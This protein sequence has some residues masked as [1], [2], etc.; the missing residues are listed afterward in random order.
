MDPSLLDPAQALALCCCGGGP[1]A[2]L[3]L[4]VLSKA[5]AGLSDLAEHYEK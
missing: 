3:L 5:G 4:F 1:L 2:I